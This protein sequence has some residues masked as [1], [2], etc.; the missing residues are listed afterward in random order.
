[1]FMRIG[2]IRSTIG[3]CLILVGASLM[4][5]MPA[6]VLAAEDAEAPPVTDQQRAGIES[7]K[8]VDELRT[9]GKKYVIK[10]QTAA[11]RLCLEKIFTIEPE[12]MIST[13]RQSPTSWNSFW[14]G[15]VA[16]LR[17]KKLKKDDAPGRVELALWL[18]EANM[19]KLARQML[20]AALEIDPKLPKAKELADEWNLFGGGPVRFDLTYGL[21]QPL[22]LESYS[23]GGEAI[24]LRK[25]RGLLLLPFAYNPGGNR[26]TIRSSY[27]KVTSN[28]S[29]S[30]SVKGILLMEHVSVESV[31]SSPQ[32][33]TKSSFPELKLQGSNQPLLWQVMITPREEEGGYELKCYSVRR[34]TSSR[35][36]SAEKSFDRSKDKEP[37]IGSGYA[38]FLVEVPLDIDYLDCEYRGLSPV[39]IGVDLLEMLA[40][41]VNDLS[42]QDIESFI[43]ALSAKAKDKYG[44]VSSAAVGK[45]ALIRSDLKG[46]SATSAAMAPIIDGALVSAMGHSDRWTGRYAFEAL[47]FDDQLLPDTTLQMIQI[48]MDKDS[49]LSMLDLAKSIIDE[50]SQAD[51]SDQTG[52]SFSI[53]NSGMG[54]NESLGKLVGA[55]KPS[56]V[57]P[58]VYK[59][60]S[61]CMNCNHADVRERA[62]GLVL[63][64]GTQY[65]ILSLLDAPPEIQEA[66]VPRLA[67]IQDDESRSAVLRVLMPRT[68]DDT[69]LSKLLDACAQTSITITD[70]NDPLLTTL[71]G[72]RSPEVIR[73]LIDLLSQAD[74]TEVSGSDSFSNILKTLAQ[75]RGKQ[76]AVWS[77]MLNMAL[78][79][80]NLPYEAPVSGGLNANAPRGARPSDTQAAGFESLLAFVA[81][82]PKGQEQEARIAAE[83]LVKVGRLSL[84]KERLKNAPK[85]RRLKLIQHLSKNKELWS[86]EALATFIAWCLMTD[87]IPTLEEGFKALDKIYEGCGPQQQW[88]I[89]LAVKYGIDIKRLA[90]LSLHTEEAIA[91]K[92]TDLLVRLSGMVPEQADEFRFI[93]GEKGREEMLN[94]LDKDQ[95]N[96][97]SGKYVCV[98]Y[99]DV[100]L[101]EQSRQSRNTSATENRTGSTGTG[102]SRGW[103]SS[104]KRGS[105]AGKERQSSASPPMHY[106]SRRN[107]PLV[108]S[109]VKSPI[110]LELGGG[111]RVLFKGRNIVIS[112]KDTRS[113]AGRDRRQGPLKID[114][115]TLLRAAL[116]SADAKQ[117]GLEGMVDLLSIRPGLQCDLRCEKLGT[118][119]GRVNVGSSGR[120]TAGHGR[121]VFNITEATIVLEPVGS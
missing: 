12:L 117:E 112:D 107:I 36:K 34:R 49:M 9:L 105:S 30:C 26:L 22:L 86:R 89:N 21:T 77:A 87:D 16:L 111:G 69:T 25:D 29:R 81:A 45:L 5:G 121:A 66:V 55:L 52:R 118:W 61:A 100:K 33:G 98:V 62:L 92:G 7:A 35:D 23:G 53:D 64:D 2:F 113:G 65:A 10:K 38:A 3:M 15:E 59:I 70:D 41:R 67:E 76:P 83:A 84:L 104:W 58:N 48:S 37:I 63:G 103:S 17:E 96:R 44:T 46:Q 54:Q 114:A 95:E 120:P 99:V 56:V 94:N 71:A 40:V 73:K 14:F 19:S 88:R 78:K 27:L 82:G 42:G 18:K 13:R 85:D 20:T 93:P 116:I 4:A 68:K 91:R 60:L 6:S 79:Q 119:S 101:D 80:F 11:A 57:S 43:E 110:V 24:K 47:A 8:T 108:V 31:G 75:E 72:H 90:G 102:V 74:L 50:V 97:P 39:R 51:A 1:M 28:D 115:A 106:S 109:P 32:G